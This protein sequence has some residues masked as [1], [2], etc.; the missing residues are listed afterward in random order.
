MNAADGL[1]LL[2]WL[3]GGIGIHKRGEIVGVGG[4]AIKDDV[5]GGAAVNFVDA[6]FRPGP[7]DPVLGLG[8]AGGF[9]FVAVLA[10]SRTAPVVGAVA[11]VDGQDGGIAAELSFPRPVEAQ[12]R[13]LVV[14]TVQL[15]S[16]AMQSIDEMPIDKQFAIG[17]DRDGLRALGFHPGSVMGLRA[18]AHGERDIVEVEG[19]GVRHEG[20]EQ[21]GDAGGVF[22]RLSGDLNARPSLGGHPD[23]AVFAG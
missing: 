19:A 3:G 13:A 9:R 2:A 7:S 15:K 21:D 1:E 6:Q 17:A 5:I 4:L 11:A 22:G 20:I 14:R 18:A 16:R 8:H 10:D 12:C 23:L